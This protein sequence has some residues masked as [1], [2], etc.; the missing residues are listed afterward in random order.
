M[1]KFCGSCG[2]QMDDNDKVCGNCGTPVP[3]AAKI[4]VPSK[5]EV[6]SVAGSD[7]VKKILPVAIVAVVA[8]VVIIVAVKILSGITG[9]NGA[10]NK[11][12]KALKDNDNEALYN[13]SSCISDEINESWY[14]E[15]FYDQYD[16]Q[17]SSVLDKYE[18]KVGN[19]K[20]ISVKINDAT[21]VSDRKFNSYREDL[22]NAYNMDT[23]AIKKMVKLD[24]TITVKGSKKS[25]VY[26]VDNLVAVKESGGWKLLY[27]S[28]L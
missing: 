18:D 13:L 3:G 6:A 20:K 24:I 28:G 2:A 23:S 9:Y 27:N 21:E 15:D 17:I 1:A 7:K 26:N 16:R 5:E 25:A 22:Q 12:A 11:M 10:V 4:N 19:I 8:V 14:G